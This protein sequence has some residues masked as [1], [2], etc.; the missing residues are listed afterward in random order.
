MYEFEKPSKSQNKRDMHALQKLGEV[1]VTLNANQLAALDL[2]P[3]LLK[4]INAAKTISSDKAKRR[5][6]QFIGKLMRG[7]D[8]DVLLRIKQVC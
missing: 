4:A 8:E 2:P 5:Q 3:D 6:H 1:L 7:I